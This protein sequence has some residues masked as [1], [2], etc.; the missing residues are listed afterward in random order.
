MRIGI[1]VDSTCD[2]PRPF[3]DEHR[4]TLLPITVHL[5]DEDFVDV[6][7][8]D[9]TAAYYR[10]SA[11]QRGHAAE[12]EPLSV[13]AIK[14]LFLDR[15][16]LDY[17]CVF[18]LTV[19]ASRSPVHERASQ[20]SFAILKD[21]RAIRQQSGNNAPFLLR[22]IDTRNLFAGQGVSAVEA[23]KLIAAESSPGRIRERLEVLTNHT[24]AY[25]MPRDLNYIRARTRKRGDR[26][27]SLF[28][29][30]LGTALDIKPILQCFRGETR[31]VGKV[32]GFEHGA[33]TLL[34]HVAERVKLGLLTR[35]VC[36]SYG[37]DLGEL[38][39][40]PGYH[41]LAATCA[42]HRTQLLASVMSI[43]GMV[44]MGTGALT[45]GFASEEYTPSF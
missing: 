29:A 6:R 30:A 33:Q 17:D 14:A 28:S 38:E 24:Y 15:L 21:Y 10:G 2:L 34:L 16:V 42:E 23:I 32:R 5:D 1:V 22:V 44:N 9:A 25:A 43:T 18:C 31:P 36:V 41:E 39:A 13:A 19:S 37:G 7:D 40:L 26:S 45:I 3:I 35:A 8:P 11:G 20:A 4:I 27:V 12:T